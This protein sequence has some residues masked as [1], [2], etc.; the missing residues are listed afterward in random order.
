MKTKLII[1][2]IGILA[3]SFSGCE[4]FLDKLENPNLVN[5]PPINGLLATATFQTGTDVFR[6]GN[7]VSY[8]NQYLAGNTK[9]SDADVYNP[10]DYTTT[11]TNFYLTTMV[12]IYQMN[13][14]AAEQGASYH[15][16]IGKILMA[17]NLN[18]LITTFGD[19]PYTEAFAGQQTL[20]PKYD[21]QQA[22]HT[23]C[24]TLL[25]EGIAELKKTGVTI[26]LDPASDVIHGGS[27]AA[28]IRTGYALKARFLNQLSKTSAY[29]AA[30]ILA[31]TAQSYTENSQ[32]ATLT[33]FSGLSPWNNVAVQNTLLNL[34]GWLSTQFVDALNGN[35][36]GVADP[37]LPLIAT[38]TK[39]GDYRGTPNGAGRIGTGTTKEESYLSVDGFYSKKSAPLLMVTNAEVRFIESEAAFRSNNRALAY[40][41]YLAGIKAHMDQLGVS[42]ANEA[43]Y[44][45]NPIVAVGQGALTLDLIFKEKYVVMFLNPEAWVDARRYDYQYKDFTLPAGAVLNTFI[46]R[47]AYPTVETSRN[48]A[49]V[50]V[51]AGLTERLFWDK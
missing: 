47:A 49:N 34:D 35:T 9:G 8:F 16:G 3:F 14:L 25:D 38:I 24:L 51:T 26:T 19:V 29:S 13:K 20:T 30:N 43:A 41:A 1:I 17:Y 22:L 18:M 40:T 37:R 5:N 48:G 15:L 36:Y 6:I 33:A 2:A 45:S 50:P 31:A 42:A 12:N 23:T 46:R 39:F 7:A 10:V 11:W 32:S 44:L 4:K 21:N 28:W 27:T